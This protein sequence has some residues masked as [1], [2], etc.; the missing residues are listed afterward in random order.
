MRRF[1]FRMFHHD[2]SRTTL[3]VDAP[4]LAEALALTVEERAAVESYVSLGS[5]DLEPQTA[6]VRLVL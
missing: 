1:E 4:D 6:L 2:G 3:S 5:R